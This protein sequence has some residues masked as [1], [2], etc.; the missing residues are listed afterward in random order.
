MFIN[1][2]AGW[3]VIAVLRSAASYKLAKR[4]PWFKFNALVIQSGACH[5]SLVQDPEKLN[6]EDKLLCIPA[7]ADRFFTVTSKSLTSSVALLR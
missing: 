5:D 6:L 3:V 1:V 7:F 2:L 4:G